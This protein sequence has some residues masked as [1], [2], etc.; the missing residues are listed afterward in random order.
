MLLTRS[1]CFQLV[2]ILPPDVSKSNQPIDY[3]PP[4]D[5]P[6]IGHNALSI[7]RIMSAPA[8]SLPGSKRKASS[9]VITHR[10]RVRTDDVAP[11]DT[12]HAAGVLIDAVQVI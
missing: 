2:A 3:L 11:V 5:H 7:A 8:P 6:Y 4:R 10:T 9:K 1:F 12:Q